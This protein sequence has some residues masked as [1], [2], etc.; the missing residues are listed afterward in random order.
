MLIG[1]SARGLRA[2]LGKMK[3]KRNNSMTW[4]A[5]IGIGAAL[6]LSAGAFAHNPKPQTMTA[7][8]EGSMQLQHIMM[9]GQKM[10][11]P[12]PMSGNVDKDF[13]TMMSAHHQMAIDMADVLL[14][15]G[16]NAE[17]KSMAMKMKA[18]QTAE[19]EE[20]APYTK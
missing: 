7:H 6:V 2:A 19:I 4:L 9:Q 10:P 16:S 3:M 13:A 17:L 12:M 5:T 1:G 20:M 18:A 11:M 14:K 15:Y 8:S